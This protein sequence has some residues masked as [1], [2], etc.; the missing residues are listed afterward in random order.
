MGDIDDMLLRLGAE[1][2]PAALAELDGAVL[3]RIG[4]RREARMVRRTM[5][6]A[7]CVAMVAGMAGTIVQ[8]GPAVAEPL[9]GVPAVAP[10]RLLAD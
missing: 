7:G 2:V 5:M 4:Q 10:S 6:L 8:A 9:L 1:P 3:A